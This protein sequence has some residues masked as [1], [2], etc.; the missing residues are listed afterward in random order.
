M[1]DKQKRSI[2]KT[3]IIVLAVLLALSVVA[4]AGTLIYNQINGNEQT[5][6]TVPENLITPEKNP[7]GGEG[8]EPGEG[9]S[10]G[11]G[12]GT[13]APAQRPTT[14][15]KKAATISLYNRQE[16]ENTPFK[17][18][19]MFP[20]DAET[21]YFRVQVSYHDKV[22]VHYRAAVRPGY[23]KLAEVLKVRVKL[24][25][26]GETMYDG[27][28]RD[29][30]ESVTY[31]LQSQSSATKDL[32]YEITAYLETAVGNEYQNKDLTADFTWWVE[33]TGNLDDSPQTGDSSNVV[34]W[35]LIALG[36]AGV[37]FL[38]LLFRRR[39]GDGKND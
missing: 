7:N 35:A 28:M 20:G 6:V 38:L 39:K 2:T 31:T 10:E 34:L 29:M 23:E 13:S 9:V 37:I 33:E 15:T 25:T 16:Q 5:T 26:S 12:G 11:E 4:L 36:S 3:I 8:A 27:L 1:M 19:N 17:V 22:T 32:Y 24:L 14:E 21:Q 18:G 30:P